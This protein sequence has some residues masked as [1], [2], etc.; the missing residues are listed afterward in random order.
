MTKEDIIAKTRAII[1]ELADLGNGGVTGDENE[2]NLIN[3][4]SANMPYAYSWLL[5]NVSVEML[6]NSVISSFSIPIKSESVTLEKNNVVRVELPNDFIRIVSAR[7]SSWAYSPT[8]VNEFSQTALM[9]QGRTTMGSPDMPAVV[10]YLIDGKKYLRMYT[11]ESDE[12]IVNYQIVKTTTDNNEYPITSGIEKAFIYYLAYLTLTSFRD[13][14]AQN[15][16]AIAVSEVK[17]GEQN[18]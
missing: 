18:G 2:E 13:P 9:Q 1:D 10:L 15:F 7:L 17:R 14:S 16:Y 11:A 3:V 12:D 6:D 4:I 8:P 5:Q